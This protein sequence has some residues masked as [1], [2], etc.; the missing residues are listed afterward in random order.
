MARLYLTTVDRRS[1]VPGVKRKR[2]LGGSIGER[3]AQLRKEAD[4]TQAG[5]A[6][7]LG[8]DKTAV[9]HWETG[10]S[11]PDL[12]RVMAVADALGVSIADLL[13]EAA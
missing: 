13:H 4:M 2:R 6:E 8:V 1:T 7:L 3:I 11:R 9:S 10:A 12:S 5:L